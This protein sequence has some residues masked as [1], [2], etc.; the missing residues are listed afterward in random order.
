[1]TGQPE[2]SERR[3]TETLE[4]A[5][6]LNAGGVRVEVD[7][8]HDGALATVVL[9]R[10]ERRN[11][12]TPATWA[13][14][15]A[16]PALLG[17]AVRV[18]VVRGE[19]PSFCAGLDLRLATPEGVPG[20][21][22]LASYVGGR[23]DAAVADQIGAWQAGFMWLRDPRWLT[24]AAVHGHAVGAGFQL[25]L[26]ADLRVVAD[27]ARFCMREAALGLVPDLTGTQPLAAC[28]GYARAL[29][30][31]ATARWVAAEEAV[32][33][34]LA[35]LA[36]PVAELA[37]AV[38]DLCAALLAN[39]AGPAAPIKE[40]LLAAGTRDL[41]AQAAAERQAQVPLLRALLGG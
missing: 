11:A 17:D 13:A 18:V 15:A 32:R 20:E 21:G 8:A 26:S 5:R 9:Q 24:V 41:A 4:A 2:A 35:N 23:T 36:V 14:L 40:L 39:P 22:T 27:D 37:G 6:L 30:I 19:G 25:A 31:C 1:M 16:V 29:E 28:V 34:G 7:P 10:G 33:I 3:T 12:M 38:A